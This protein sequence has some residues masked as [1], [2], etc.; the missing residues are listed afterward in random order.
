[1]RRVLM[2]A[3]LLMGVAMLGCSRDGLTSDQ[4]AALLMQQD[5]HL[6]RGMM[7]MLQEGQVQSGPYSLETRSDGRVI[8][9]S[10]AGAKPQR[11]LI[12]IEQKRLVPIEEITSLP[13]QN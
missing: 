10:R 7:A 12:D 4:R 6:H 3:G 13:V 5:E 9:V 1:M 8:L 2:A 11:Y